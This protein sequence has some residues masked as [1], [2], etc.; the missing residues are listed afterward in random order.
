MAYRFTSLTEIVSNLKPGPAGMV[1]RD[2][3]NDAYIYNK[4]D[5]VNY[6]GSTYICVENGTVGKNPV[7]NTN[8]WDLVAQGGSG[9]SGNLFL[10]LIDDGSGLYDADASQVGYGGIISVSGQ[11]NV[12]LDTRQPE[13][14]YPVGSILEFWGIYWLAL[15]AYH[16]LPEEE[17]AWDMVNADSVMMV[18]N[19]KWRRT[20]D[21][22]DQN[23][24][25][26]PETLIP[27]ETKF[28]RREG[29][30]DL[31]WIWVRDSYDDGNPT[32]SGSEEPLWDNNSWFYDGEGEWY[33]WSDPVKIW[34]SGANVLINRQL[35]A[36]GYIWN[37]TAWGRE[38]ISSQDLITTSD[39]TNEGLDFDSDN[40]DGE[41]HWVEIYN[42]LPITVMT[43]ALQDQPHKLE[44]NPSNPIL[45]L[46]L[47]RN[48]FYSYNFYDIYSYLYFDPRYDMWH[49]PDE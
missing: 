47:G 5:V 38:G 20:N 12:D 28:L 23:F 35:A 48:G 41:V 33:R 9:G 18:G 44:I 39:A 3:Y 43:L 1:W 15:P 42:D 10:N 2:T 27:D 8:E 45:L 4:S 11:T 46:G 16:T 30:S 17:P 22:Y 24:V 13:T 36:D 34:E 26:E 32:L 40:P 14:S 21:T 25:W 37:C 29:D 7:Q 19:Q 6:N 49:D 31:Y